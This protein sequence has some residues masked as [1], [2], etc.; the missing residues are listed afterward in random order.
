[1]YLDFFKFKKSPFHITPDPDFL[2]LNQSHKEASASIFYGI[3]ER[4]GFIAITGEVGVGKTTILRSYLEG[5]DPERV[6]IVYVFNASI[7]FD[8]LLKLIVSELGIEVV[9]ETP[10]ELVDSLFHHLID[11]Y[12]NDRNVVLIIDEA[13][14]MPVETLE[15]LRMLSNLETS[16]DKLLQIIL[17]GQ[18]EFEGKLNLPELR[19]LKQRVA[20]RCRIDALTPEES[21]AY[22]QHRLMKASQFHNPV[23][24]RGALRRVVKEAK[25]IPR[26]INVLCDNALVTA[27]G[28]QRN[29]VDDKI[30][31]EVIKDFQGRGHRVTFSRRVVWV[32]LL[33]L[34]GSVGFVSRDIVR[35]ENIP[36]A[37]P[38]NLT[39]QA[40]S[41][42]YEQPRQPKQVP[43][44]AATGGFD[45][46]KAQSDAKAEPAPAASEAPA[47]G[48]VEMVGPPDP[49][50]PSLPSKL[51]PESSLGQASEKWGWS[52]NPVTGDKLPQT[53]SEN[54][55]DPAQPS[56]Q[57]QV[58]PPPG[59]DWSPDYTLPAHVVKR[60][61]S[62]SKL[63][64]NSFGRVDK[65]LLKS[66]QEVN[67]QIKNINKIREGE[68]IVL[69][70]LGNN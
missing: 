67:P 49:P 30:I 18:P 46:D 5:T 19:Q 17:V 32:S 21:F 16:R 60:G 34:V 14:N 37:R 28:Y 43:P 42:A 53:G 38:E 9:D 1:M 41:P 56:V 13:Q 61:D 8:R 70:K 3:E 2:F 35:Q 23:F 62:V 40:P 26:I 22:I 50:T 55:T 15:R 31:K 7:S 36:A 25:G 11:E 29:P 6:R 24:T 48:R 68:E 63:L 52:T 59:E 47:S 20:I 44:A 39:T 65:E 45:V 57:P 33:V 64:V 10:S 54:S 51:V 58:E 4:K 66:F 27:F 12:K 69:P